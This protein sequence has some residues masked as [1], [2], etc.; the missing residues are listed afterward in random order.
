[1][2]QRLTT[3][4]LGRRNYDPVYAIPN[5]GIRMESWRRETFLNSSDQTASNNEAVRTII[6]RSGR[7][8]NGTQTVGTKQGIWKDNQINGYGAVL[9]DA[10]DDGYITDCNLGSA[11][12]I[13]LV[14]NTSS[15]ALRRSLQSRDGNKV[16][17]ASR[18]NFAVFVGSDAAV[19]DLSSYGGQWTILV[20][21]VNG[22]S[23]NVRVNGT[24]VTEF[25]NRG[26]T[27]GRIGIGAIGSFME[28]MG[29][30]LA[31]LYAFT[32]EITLDET[33]SLE[34]YLSE[35]TTIELAP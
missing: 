16:I 5:L 9:L 23:I 14:S 26:G 22:T 34:S 15:S 28:P 29:G 12:S 21:R 31:A 4:V 25:S 11:Y 32:R 24:D 6:D 20:V 27:F 18:S 8:F 13:V 1:M 3:G 7:V 30:Y 33:S 35:K 19:T 2:S 17:S 10:V